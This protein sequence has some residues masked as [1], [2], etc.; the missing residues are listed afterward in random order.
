MP[1]LDDFIARW[2]GSHGSERANSQRFL[3]ELILSL[4][5]PPMP[6]AAEDAPAYEF[7][8]QVPYKDD[9]GTVHDLR[10][11]L[12]KRGCFVLESKQGM[13]VRERTPLEQIAATVETAK[14]RVF[15]FLD[16]SILPDNMLVNIATDDAFFLGV[17]SSRVHVV[18]ALAAGGRLGMGNDPRYN[19]SRC[20]ETFPFPDPTEAQRQRIRNAA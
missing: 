1:Q 4:G 19:K 10:I 17:L 8:H 13:E 5:L 3:T 14:H 2:S 9:S 20:F 18:W 6:T 11:D 7:E 15:V 12:Y 16:A